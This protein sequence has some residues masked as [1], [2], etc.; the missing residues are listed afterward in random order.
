MLVA[1]EWNCWREYKANVFFFFSPL[2]TGV[3]F[4]VSWA[5][6]S[7]AMELLMAI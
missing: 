4:L 5:L 2:I 7:R 3:G 6:V 1:G